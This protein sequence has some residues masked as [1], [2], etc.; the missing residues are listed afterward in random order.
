MSILYILDLIIH[1]IRKSHYYWETPS[2]NPEFFVFLRDRQIFFNH[3]MSFSFQ[4]F[5]LVEKRGMFLLTY[6]IFPEYDDSFFF[7]K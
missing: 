7:E 3:V 4:L 1:N 6:P 5:H 2:S